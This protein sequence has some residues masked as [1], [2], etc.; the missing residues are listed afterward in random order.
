VQQKVVLL[1]ALHIVKKYVHNKMDSLVQEDLRIKQQSNGS[2]SCHLIPFEDLDLIVE[3]F[4][5]KN[6]LGIPH[7]NE[8]VL[9]NVQNNTNIQEELFRICPILQEFPFDS[10]IVAGGSLVRLVVGRE[11]ENDIDIFFHGPNAQDALNYVQDILKDFENES[12]GITS[13]Y[14]VRNVNIQLIK[15]KFP[16]RGS[17]LFSFDLACC[18]IGCT[19]SEI[20]MTP[21]AKHCLKTRLVPILPESMTTQTIYRL[22]T[23]YA[24]MGFYPIWPHFE[25]FQ[26]R[27]INA[28]KNQIVLQFDDLFVRGFAQKGIEYVDNEI[29]T[30]YGITDPAIPYTTIISQEELDEKLDGL[31][32]KKS[33]CVE[34]NEVPE[35]KIPENEIIVELDTLK[36]KYISE[37]F[38]ITNYPH[39][40]IISNQ[41]NFN[42][43]ID[44]QY[45]DNFY[46]NAN[47][48]LFAL[49]EYILDLTMRRILKDEDI[50]LITILQSY[51]HLINWNNYISK[52]FSFQVLLFDFE[53]VQNHELFQNEKEYN[54]YCEKALHCFLKNNEIISD[55]I[56]NKLYLKYIKINHID[57][58]MYMN[59]NQS[60]TQIF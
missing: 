51:D 9:R 14:N 19:N 55:E 30:Y 40:N 20:F 39:S 25:K 46:F 57:A 58:L 41:I 5:D 8:N 44:A 12:K 22:A 3:D 13:N 16:D 50:D 53:S 29:I 60:F 54:F 38:K 34:Q 11:I 36:N 17:I 48:N 27:I 10:C 4:S 45:I 42:W 43:T 24:P 7:T 2:W 59:Q 6:I 18:A 52:M 33:K 49:K 26:T 1:L 31:L 23:K 32:I 21:L 47:I 35:N 15:I 28:S 56:K 37:Y